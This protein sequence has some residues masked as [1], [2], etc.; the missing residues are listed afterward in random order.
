V[1]RVSNPAI[2]GRIFNPAAWCGFSIRTAP[3]GR[4]S[5]RIGNPHHTRR[6]GNSAYLALALLLSALSA[7]AHN[8]DTSYARIAIAEDRVALRLTYD[9]F[10]LQKIAAVDADR[11]GQVTR[12]EVQRAAPEIEAFLRSRVHLEIEGK[13]SGLGEA[14]PPEWPREAPEAIAA[15]DWHSAAALMAFPFSLPLTQPARDVTIIFQ[16]FDVFGARHTVLGAFEHRGHTEEVVF[17][18]E[19]PDYLFDTSYIAGAP[20]APRSEPSLLANLRRWIVLGAEHI[21]IGYDHI[22]FLLAL[23]VV[24]RFG[25]LVKIVTSFTV[26]H[27]LTLI[28]AALGVATLPGRLVECAIALTIVYVAVENLWRTQLAYRWKLTFGFGLIHGFGFAGVLSELGLPTAGRVRCLLAFNLGIEF[29]QLAIVAVAF[30]FFL[31]LRKW[32]PF[33]VVVSVA[34]GLFGLGWFL[35]RAFGLGF[36]PV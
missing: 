9:L 20:E 24:S 2:V 13:S 1:G 8:P 6:V 32:R 16:F 3:P 5:V 17:M 29:G 28:L 30:P 12:A 27:S 34:I 22:C 10:T 26:A 15:A 23:L 19:E 36:M 31:L 18:E 4:K 35:E 14:S 21:F 33:P 25:E 7:F 11:D